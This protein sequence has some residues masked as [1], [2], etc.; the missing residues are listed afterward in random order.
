MEGWTPIFSTEAHNIYAPRGN[1]QHQ[2]GYEIR[3]LKRSTH[4]DNATHRLRDKRSWL[5]NLSHH[6]GYETIYV[7]NERIRRRR[8]EAWPSDMDLCS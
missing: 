7:T 3:S 2:M 4:S 6:L 8:S 5:I 1:R